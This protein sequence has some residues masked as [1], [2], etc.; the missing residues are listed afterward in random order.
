[1]RNCEWVISHAFNSP[2]LL[3]SQRLTG[4]LARYIFELSSGHSPP[5][6]KKGHSHLLGTIAKMRV[7]T[8]NVETEVMG[9]KTIKL[10]HHLPCLHR[11]LCRNAKIST[12]ACIFRGT[13]E[14][15]AKQVASPSHHP[16]SLTIGILYGNLSWR[17]GKI[18]DERHKK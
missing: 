7:P 5:N 6:L 4:S 9:G 8:N 1:V 17:H 16:L 15:C 10:L 11:H 14:Q 12:K 3:P 18:I 2:P 13:R